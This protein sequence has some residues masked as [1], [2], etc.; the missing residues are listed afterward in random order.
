MNLVVCGVNHRTL[1]VAQR[2][3]LAV[4]QPAAEEL[5]ELLRLEGVDEALVLSTCNRVEVYGVGA[6]PN[7]L[8]DL[9][10]RA[11]S[12]TIIDSPDCTYAHQGMDA[13]RMKATGYADIKPKAPNRDAQG[14]PI[15]ENQSAN[16]RVTLRIYPMSLAE[17]KAFEA[18]V[19][20]EEEKALAAEQAP[21][22]AE[23]STQPKNSQPGTAMPEAAPSGQ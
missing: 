11:D 15:P 21:A 12:D 14:N 16:R 18:F 5:L 10:A 3:R 1:P 9:I 17:R 22:A 4:S 20:K 6:R 23:P 8:R 13:I 7:D 2:E 19:A